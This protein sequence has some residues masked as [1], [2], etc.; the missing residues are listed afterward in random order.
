MVEFWDEDEMGAPWPEE[1]TPYDNDLPQ[2]F[3]DGLDETIDQF[4]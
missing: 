3:R 2:F 4:Q 1:F